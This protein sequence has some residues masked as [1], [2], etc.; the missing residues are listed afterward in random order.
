MFFR[1]T[2]NAGAKVVP[3]KLP[4]SFDFDVWE[5][6]IFLP[7]D[8]FR[9]GEDANEVVDGDCRHFEFQMLY[10]RGQKLELSSPIRQANMGLRGR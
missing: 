8:R 6:C 10:I 4:E 3:L 1:G 9:G 2:V 7:E 5:A